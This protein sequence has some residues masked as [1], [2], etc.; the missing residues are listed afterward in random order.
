MPAT[1]NE[2]ITIARAVEACATKL[3][4]ARVIV[5]Q[6]LSRDAVEM[7]DWADADEDQVDDA[8]ESA[9]IDYRSEE[10]AEARDTLEQF[11]NFWDEQPVVQNEHGKILEKLCQ[12]IV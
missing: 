8:L 12:P 6:T 5:E 2:I 9:G 11:R 7:I 4:Q 10:I 3:K 1:T